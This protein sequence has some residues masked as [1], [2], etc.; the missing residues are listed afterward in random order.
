[1]GQ[2][3]WIK[4]TR[5][6]LK[7]RDGCW[8]SYPAGAWQFQGSDDGAAWTT[9][10][11]V[12]GSTTASWADRTVTTEQYFRQFRWVFNVNGYVEIYEVELMG[13]WTL[14][15]PPST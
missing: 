12:S 11:D 7:S 2:S 15:A 1:M 3:A 10:D 14:V 6:R 8:P 9:L 4:P 5:Y 13:C